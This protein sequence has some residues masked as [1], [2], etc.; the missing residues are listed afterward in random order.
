MNPELPQFPLK[1]T[2]FST[3]NPGEHGF[4]KALITDKDIFT[5]KENEE[6]FGTG[7]MIQAG[8]VFNTDCTCLEI[9][10]DGVLMLMDGESTLKKEARF[11]K[12]ASILRMFANSQD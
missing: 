7:D 9:N 1:V 2:D 4:A 5:D 8:V 6:T 10:A 3:S 11:L 12:T